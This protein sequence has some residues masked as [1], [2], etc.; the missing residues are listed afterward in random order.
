MTVSHEP[1]APAGG[2]VRRGLAFLSSTIRRLTPEAWNQSPNPPAP[3]AGYQIRLAQEIKAFESCKNVHELPEIFHYWSN[4]YLVPKFE[5]FGFRNAIEFVCLYITRVC[6][7]FPAESCR[8]VS[9]G[10]G[11]CDLEI[12]I[13]ERVVA[14]GTRNFTL[15]CIDVN[16]DML[17]RGRSLAEEKGLA[18]QMS[19]TCVDLNTWRPQSQCHIVIAIQCLHH[20]VGLESLFETIRRALHPRGFFLVDDM[21]GRNGHMRWPEA[22][23]LVNDI[24]NDLPDKYKYNHQLKRLDLEFDNW[25]CSVEGFEGIRSQDIL[26]LLIAHFHFDFFIAFGNVIDVFIDRSFGHNY[27][28]ASAHDRA[29]IDRIHAIDDD[30]I[31]RG[32]VTPTHMLAAMSTDST[33]P[34]TIYKHLTPEFCVRQSRGEP[35]QTPAP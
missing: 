1:G 32:I 4:T 24:W 10:S 15:E 31:E 6:R 33:G 16:R 23:T 20:F 9:I 26:P 35:R 8:L 2:R 3:D 7:A 21:I 25:D 13:V 27:D 28:A 17:R 14:S 22:L 29:I 11:N 19:F 30:A 12:Q 5:P 34:T 18:D